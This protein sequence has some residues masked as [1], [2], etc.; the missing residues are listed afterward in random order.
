[1]T[2]HL[3]AR[4]DI[5]ALA[6]TLPFGPWARLSSGVYTQFFGSEISI[7]ATSLAQIIGGVSPAVQAITE[8]DFLWIYTPTEN[9]QIG[10]HGVNAQTS[11]W[12]L[13]GGRYCLVDGSIINALS[14]YNTAAI[15]ALVVIAVGQ[16]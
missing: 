15:A 16:A 13:A 5:E 12:T 10:L 11:G 7:D 3:H 14:I 4:L 9:I 6:S 8:I 2:T 1:M